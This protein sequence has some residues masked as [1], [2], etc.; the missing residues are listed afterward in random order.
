VDLSIK[1]LEQGIAAKRQSIC[2]DIR[3][4]IM[5][6]LGTES[7]PATVGHIAGARRALE[8]MLDA[9]PKIA[10]PGIMIAGGS[11]TSPAFAPKS[12]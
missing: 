4:L 7:G 5:E 2:R 10:E 9:I 11:S 6:A 1:E 12:P 8:M 3:V